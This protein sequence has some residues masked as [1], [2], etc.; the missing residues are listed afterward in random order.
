[1][2]EGHLCVQKERT[3]GNRLDAERLSVCT[4]GED[5]RGQA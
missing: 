4:G 5:W 2:Q 1:M 3:G